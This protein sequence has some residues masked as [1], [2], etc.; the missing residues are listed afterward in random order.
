MSGDYVSK[1]TAINKIMENIVHQ[2]SHDVNLHNIGLRKAMSAIDSL[3]A[4][5]VVPVRHGKWMSHY[6]TEYAEAVK[7][8]DFGSVS[9]EVSCS[10]C[11]A[12][13]GGSAE[14]EVKG[15]YCPNCGARMDGGP[16]A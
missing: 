6:G 11:G 8:S 14:Y 1:A 13:L 4:A 12:Y 3:P 16:D 2:D 5:D 10:E 7:V 9:Q 15:N